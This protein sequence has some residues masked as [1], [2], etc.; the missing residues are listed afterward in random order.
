MKLEKRFV[1]MISG[2]LAAVMIMFAFVPTAA[3][4]YYPYYN[5]Y[6]NYGY[7]GYH[8]RHHDHHWTKN[9]T[10]AVAGIAAVIGLLALANKKPKTPPSDPIS[11]AEYRDKYVANLNVQEQ[12]VC[13]MLLSYPAGEYKSAYTQK[14]T[15]KMVQ[16]FCK[17]LP[18]DFQFVGT[19]AV[20]FADGSI[21]NYVYFN[22]LNSAVYN[23]AEYSTVVVE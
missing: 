22:R 12:S 2:F 17:K 8:H 23:S 7:Y 16:K 3:F 9:D 15:L 6:Y 10:A 5:H 18:K 11:Y 4:A 13:N 1:K 21:K 20:R 19:R 14:A